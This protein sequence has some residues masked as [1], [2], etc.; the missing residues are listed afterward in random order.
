MDA[1]FTI[2]YIGTDK[3]ICSDVFLILLD[4]AV[5]QRK[6]GL[7]LVMGKRQILQWEVIFNQEVYFY[8]KIM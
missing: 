1:A 4:S 2:E 8:Y 3:K 5:R 7:A 6:I